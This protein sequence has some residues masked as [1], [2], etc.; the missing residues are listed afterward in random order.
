MLKG[1]LRG[2]LLAAISNLRYLQK[3]IEVIG[4]EMLKAL[5]DL[6]RILS[7]EEKLFR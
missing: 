1:L 4:Q 5:L 7:L 6:I 2:S 3:R